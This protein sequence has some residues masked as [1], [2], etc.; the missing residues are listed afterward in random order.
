MVPVWH[1]L[2]ARRGR[3]AAFRVLYLDEASESAAAFAVLE[4]A[5]SRVTPTFL[6]LDR[7][8][9][10]AARFMGATSYMAISGALDA[11]P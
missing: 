1:L 10:P 3:D 7:K 4:A 9:R 6:V 5:R 8:G 2:E 11:L